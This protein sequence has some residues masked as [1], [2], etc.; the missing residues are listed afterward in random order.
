MDIFPTKGIEY[1]LIIGYLSAFVPFAW[2]LS[3]IG[4]DA[5][6]E[7]PTDPDSP[8]PREAPLG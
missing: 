1:L 5:A 7:E 2:L 6:D 3:R 8:E 4:R